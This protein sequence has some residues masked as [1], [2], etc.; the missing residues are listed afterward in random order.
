MYTV[1]PYFVAK[2]LMDIPVML[3]TPLVTAIVNYFAF[4]LY[5]SFPQFA[6]FYVA[7]LLV[8]LTAA[9][10]GYF[11]SASFESDIVAQSMAPLI[12][13][14]FILFGGL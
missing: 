13:F 1:L 2:N 11:I 4:G 14:P 9:S 6:L 3:I 5:L 10:L 12:V 7:I 8:S